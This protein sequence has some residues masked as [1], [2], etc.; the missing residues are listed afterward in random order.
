MQFP[1]RD[2]TDVQSAIVDAGRRPDQ[3]VSASAGTDKAV[4]G[5][6]AVQGDLSSMAAAHQLDQAVSEAARADQSVQGV[7][8]V[9]GTLVSASEDRSSSN[10]PVNVD[11]SGS[12]PVDR[13][14]PLEAGIIPFPGPAARRQ[15]GSAGGTAGDQRNAAT[16][17]A[18]DQADLANG[19]INGARGSQQSTDTHT[20]PAFAATTP[21]GFYT[22]DEGQH[23]IDNYVGFGKA[24][25]ITCPDL[26]RSPTV[27]DGIVNVCPST[28]KIL[29]QIRTA[30]VLA[31]FIVDHL[32]IVVNKQGKDHGKAIPA[33]HLR[34]MLK[35]Q[36]FLDCFRLHQ[37]ADS[38]ARVLGWLGSEKPDTWLR[39]AEWVATA[40]QSGHA[41]Q[42]IPPEE[43]G[44]HARISAIG[45][46]L[47]R[48]TNTLFWV[49]IED[50]MVE[51]RLEGR[52]YRQDPGAQAKMRY[53]FKVE[54]RKPIASDVSSPEH[55]PDGGDLPAIDSEADAQLID[56]LRS[57]RKESDHGR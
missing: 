1:R 5:V 26:Y 12:I 22:W 10:P 46:L 42:L 35:T 55:V 25:A 13:A 19:P 24:L 30:D 20:G 11:Q 34:I 4:P 6:Q 14:E 41:G 39:P 38:I 21:I 32:R 3:A 36:A 27:G 43:R 50:E 48:Y 7:Q 8:A 33:G 56:A 47:S 9:Q 28:G 45:R 37:A 44:E 52:R 15:G 31:A 17:E 29:R 40:D 54:R 53:R 2:D 51:L 57:R 49:E 16:V 23:P 18:T